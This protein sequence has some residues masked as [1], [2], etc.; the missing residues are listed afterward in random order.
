M[1]GKY[2]VTGEAI[3]PRN[4]YD[5]TDA[6]PDDPAKSIVGAHAGPFYIS[7]I[8]RKVETVDISHKD[9]LGFVTHVPGRVSFSVVLT[10]EG[11]INED[12]L[13]AAMKEGKRVFLSIE[14]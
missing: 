10:P 4:Y 11:A 1:K 8:K 14:D 6:R 7:K 12:A 2:V 5:S 13:N 9:L 3:L